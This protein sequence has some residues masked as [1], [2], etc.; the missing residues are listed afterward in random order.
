MCIVQCWCLHCYC[1]CC[2]LHFNQCLFVCLSWIHCPHSTHLLMVSNIIK[3][4]YFVTEK[5]SFSRNCLILH[6]MWIGCLLTKAIFHNFQIDDILRKIYLIFI[7]FVKASRRLLQQESENDP[8]QFP[9]VCLSVDQLWCGVENID[10]LFQIAHKLILT[11][12]KECV[13]FGF[14]NR[15]FIMCGTMNILTHRELFPANARKA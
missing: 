15:V 3:I 9:W 13:A 14:S 5:N 10:K 2:L 11:K 1:W 4:I 6:K 8:I 7:I 12:K